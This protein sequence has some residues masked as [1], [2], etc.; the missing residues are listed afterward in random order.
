MTKDLPIFVD[1][2]ALA[3]KS[4]VLQGFIPLK[5]MSRLA[6]SLSHNAGQ[7]YIDWTFSL[8]DQQRLLIQGT[9]QAELSME[10]QRCLETLSLALN[11][12]VALMT[13]HPHQTEAELLPN[14]EVLNLDSVP[15]LLS[16]L[17]EDELIL[18]L[19][20]VAMHEKCSPPLY[21]MSQESDFIE[22]RHNPFQILSKLKKC[23]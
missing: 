6:E 19:P 2:I 16:A 5:S 3:E 1:P 22:E 17:V 10:C 13:L 15:L 4:V 14:F 8:D 7:A 11:I 20:L 12:A 9:V 18:A 23:Q 21:A